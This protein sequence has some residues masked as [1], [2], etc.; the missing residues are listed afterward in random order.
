MKQYYAERAKEHDK[1]YLKPE[2]Q[3]DIKKIHEYLKDAFAG[4]NVLEVACGTRYWTQT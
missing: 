4:M 2:R 3:E 1:V